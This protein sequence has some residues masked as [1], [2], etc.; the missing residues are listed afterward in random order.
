M[1]RRIL[2]TTVVLVLGAIINIAVAW[3]ITVQGQ[4]EPPPLWRYTTW[5][6]GG[7]IHYGHVFARRHFTRVM[8]RNEGLPDHLRG[9]HGLN[10]QRNPMYM[11]DL[12]LPPWSSAS[13]A[14]VPAD[15]PQRPPT[16]DDAGGWPLLALGCTMILAP[17]PSL[18]YTEVKTGIP[19]SP[20]QFAGGWA[21]P[22]ALPLQPIWPGFAI[23]ALLYAGI[24]WLLFAAPFALRR[25][26]RG[27]RIKRGRCPA[28]AYPIGESDVC[29]ECGKPVK[30]KEM[31]A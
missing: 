18:L 7:R 29:T 12:K 17:P 11:P 4:N 25:R 21:Y 10:A 19:I 5:E 13:L 30:P 6:A 3:M 14:Q 23:N 8:Y 26:I 1:K 31:A 28:C 2:I 15:S 20:R 24:L 16:L 9:R 22:R 27:G